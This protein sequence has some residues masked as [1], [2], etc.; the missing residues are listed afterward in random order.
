MALQG[1]KKKKILDEVRDVLRSGHY[2]R[3]TEKAYCDWIR[4]YILFHGMQSR[5]DLTGGEEKIGR[6][7]TS[8][9]V[10]NNI[11]SAT[12]KQAL[13]AL[14]FLY[15]KVLND[16]L[17][18]TINVLR[19]AKKRKIPVVLSREE[20]SLILD[21]MEGTLQLITKLL[22]GSGLRMSE[23]VRLRAR[24]IDFGM[25]Q[26]VV[27]NGK[28]NK[29]RVTPLPASLVPLLQNQLD[30]ARAVHDRDISL[31]FGE[32]YLPVALARKY[33]KAV[34]DFGW[35]YVFPAGSLSKDPRTGKVRRHHIDRSMV[36]KAIK[37]AAR[38][39]GV[40]KGVTGHTFRHSFA[41][42]LLQRGTDIRTIQA[43]LGH[44]DVETTMI[45]THVLQQGGQGVASPLDDL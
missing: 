6:F 5:A 29:D 15:K 23:A 35:Q 44:N 32:A 30:R 12:Q 33:G 18:Q 7:L 39:A 2:S 24:D 25:K 20:V 38:R 27:R 26:I 41:T 11:S 21:L 17:P 43:L 31:G 14:V 40:D 9:V 34:Q 3:N 42:H 8:L 10:D 19:S 37:S 1:E 16:P 45:Y 36:R 28:G 4:R 22:Y 13:N